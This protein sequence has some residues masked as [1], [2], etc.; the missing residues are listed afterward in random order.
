M[1]LVI[2]A[3]NNEQMNMHW[4]MHVCSMTIQCLQPFGMLIHSKFKL[5]L[6]I[7]QTLRS[8]APLTIAGARRVYI[9]FASVSPL[10]LL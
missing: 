5:K 2:L 8:Q 6:A 10:S 1:S 4:G 9:K 3:K 7:K